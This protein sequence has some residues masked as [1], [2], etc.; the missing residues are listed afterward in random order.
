MKNAWR[1]SPTLLAA[2][3]FPP[4]SRWSFPIRRSRVREEANSLFLLDKKKPY[5]HFATEQLH[6]LCADLSADSNVFFSFFLPGLPRRRPGC[7]RPTSSAPTT[8]TGAAAAAARPTPTL[9]AA[10]AC[11]SC[12][13]P[14]PPPPQPRSQSRGFNIR[15]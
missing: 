13:R 15:G 3:I 11:S 2:V 1:F 4:R 12:P 5:V 8:T 14:P 10:A 9:A 6:V 7:R